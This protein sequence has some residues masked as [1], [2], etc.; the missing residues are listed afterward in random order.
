M[1]RAELR[2]DLRARR[3]PAASPSRHT[4]NADLRRRPCGTDGCAFTL[5]ASAPDPM[6]RKGKPPKSGS[7]TSSITIRNEMKRRERLWWSA[8]VQPGRAPGRIHRRPNP[9]TH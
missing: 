8:L 6:I 7:S 4:L 9:S 1:L 3:A 5:I 2:P